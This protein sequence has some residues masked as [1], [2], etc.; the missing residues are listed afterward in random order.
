MLFSTKTV[1]LV[2]LCKS[3]FLYDLLRL[4]KISVKFYI[5]AKKE[6]NSNHNRLLALEIQGSLTTVNRSL[7]LQRQ[8]QVLFCF[9]VSVLIDILIICLYFSMN[10][11][12]NIISSRDQSWW[13]IL[14]KIPYLI[15]F[16]H[17][18]I[19]FIS[20][21]RNS[22]TFNNRIQTLFLVS[23]NKETTSASVVLFLSAASKFLLSIKSHFLKFITCWLCFGIIKTMILCL[24]IVSI[25]FK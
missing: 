9:S 14:S 18:I 7:R 2:H 16:Y 13:I 11:A 3:P 1:M 20:L 19:I 25:F 4:L 24:N 5:W 17:L 21:L 23:L 12:F 15:F 10:Q 8:T 6:S 22:V